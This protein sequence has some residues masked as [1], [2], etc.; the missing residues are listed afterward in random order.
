MKKGKCVVVRPELSVEDIISI[1][2]SQNNTATQ[3]NR[4]GNVSAFSKALRGS[5]LYLKTQGY[6]KSTEE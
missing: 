1:R 6:L 5:K 4:K 2:N 3:N